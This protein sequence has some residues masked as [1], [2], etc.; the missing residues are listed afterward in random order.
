MDSANYSMATI[1]DLMK[2]LPREFVISIERQKDMPNEWT[3]A[4]FLEAF[5]N[6]LIL[7]SLDEAG[8]AKDTANDTQKDLKYFQSQTSCVLSC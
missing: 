8:R 6:E 3:A 2:L 7:K 1:P 5:W 4:K